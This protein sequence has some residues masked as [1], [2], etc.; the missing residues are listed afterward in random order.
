M[1]TDKDPIVDGTRRL[2]TKL[3]F[4]R[5]YTL[6]ICAV[7]QSLWISLELPPVVLLSREDDDDDEETFLLRVPQAR[8]V[9]GQCNHNQLIK[10]P[11]RPWMPKT[12]ITPIADKA[13]SLCTRTCGLDCEKES[14]QS[15][16]LS[17]HS[18]LE[19]SVSHK[20]RPFLHGQHLVLLRIVEDLHG[21]VVRMTSC[22]QWMYRVY[23]LRRTLSG[24]RR[25]KKSFIRTLHLFYYH[26]FLPAQTFRL[27]R[28]PL[29]VNFG[30]QIFVFA[31]FLCDFC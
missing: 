24:L 15:L 2:V 25:P 26:F 3:K 13:E 1:P 22:F 21:L 7:H 11:G 14:C 16:A 5:R 27:I 23:R 10:T 19:H 4:H 20:H 9:P 6:Q 29:L 31:M 18:V 8:R 28:T 12:P 17:I 30:N